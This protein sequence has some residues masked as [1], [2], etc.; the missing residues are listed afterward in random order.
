LVLARLF[1]TAPSAF[2][3]RRQV[4]ST[5]AAVLFTVPY[6]GALI[7]LTTIL[8]GV[9][10]ASTAATALFDFVATATAIVFDDIIEGNGYGVLVVSIIT[11]TTAALATG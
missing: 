5:T 7:S 10:V 6:V 1:V 9:L 4:H 2:H 11:A 8:V 3:G